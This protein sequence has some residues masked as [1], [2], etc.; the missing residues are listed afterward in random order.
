MK[1]EEAKFDQEVVVIA[2]GFYK[3]A[4][5]RIIHVDESWED[6]VADGIWL[7]GIWIKTSNGHG[8]HINFKLKDL[9]VTNKSKRYS[10]ERLLG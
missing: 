6:D 8:F 4:T 2:E 5:G 1:L 9:D 10:S 3:G 7:A